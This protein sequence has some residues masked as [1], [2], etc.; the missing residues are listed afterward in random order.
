MND[1]QTLDS[2]LNQTLDGET[3]PL[4]VVIFPYQYMVDVVA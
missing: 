1:P 3:V 4:V 2:R